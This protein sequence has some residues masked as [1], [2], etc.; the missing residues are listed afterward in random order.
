MSSST[1]KSA[2]SK[3]KKHRDQSPESTHRSLE[4]KSPKAPKPLQKSPKVINLPLRESPKVPKPLHKSP[5][6]PKPLR[7][8]SPKVTKPFRKS[9]PVSK[10]LCEFPKLTKPKPNGVTLLLHHRQS[11]T[12]LHLKSQQLQPPPRLYKSWE[13]KR[14]HQD[15]EAR[16]S[17]KSLAQVNTKLTPIAQN[18]QGGSPKMIRSLSCDSLDTDG[19]LALYSDAPKRYS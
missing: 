16:F 19:W 14:A 4:I 9:L 13:E 1:R 8:E 12:S 3:K 2:D 11:P 18:S 7:R 15:N 17:N 10:P 6:V 5:K